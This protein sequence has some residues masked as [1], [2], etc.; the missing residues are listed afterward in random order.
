MDAWDGWV[1]FEGPWFPHPWDQVEKIRN[2][3]NAIWADCDEPLS[4]DH[5]VDPIVNEQ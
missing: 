3:G 1:N 4:N 2:G 5:V